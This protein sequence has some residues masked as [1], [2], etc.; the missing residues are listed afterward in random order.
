MP[1]GERQEQN[2]TVPKKGA[3]NVNGAPK[4]GYGRFIAV[5]TC[6]CFMPRRATES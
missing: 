1:R 4:H 6:L 5:Y 2:V 3:L